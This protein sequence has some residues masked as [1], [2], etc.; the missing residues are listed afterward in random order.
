MG[1]LEWPAVGSSVFSSPLVEFSAWFLLWGWALSRCGGWEGTSAWTVPMG[2]GRGF[3]AQ[4][5][6]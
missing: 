4:S 2:V 3:P 5:Y 1:A 6:S